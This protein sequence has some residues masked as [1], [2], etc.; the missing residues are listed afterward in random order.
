MA[1]Q[2]PQSPG[3]TVDDSSVGVTAWT[4][5]NNTQVSDAVYATA[6]I[7]DNSTT[8]S[9]SSIR[10]VK[11]GVISGSDLS[12]GAAWP[13]PAEGYLSY[14]GSSNLWGL[15]LSPADVNSSNFGV[16]LS[17]VGF[18]TSHY[19]KATNFGFTIPAGATINGVLVEPQ[20]LRNGVFNATANIDYIR[21]T[22][23]YTDVVG[24]FS[25]ALV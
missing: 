11:G 7:G 1:T 24:G 15:S 21:I 19:L 17:C 13:T 25:I 14:G 9:T 4:N 8:L 5:P 16:V 10:L 20:V 2:G 22:V 18:L 6:V 3:T 12:D 23:S